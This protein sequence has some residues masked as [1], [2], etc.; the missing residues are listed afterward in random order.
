MTIEI[1]P[2]QSWV[3]YLACEEIQRQVW[4]AHDNRDIVP[5]SLLVTAAK[6][7]GVLLCAFHG[8]E[9][10]GFVFGFLGM[11]P[12][13]SQW[14]FKHCSHML[15]VLQ[16]YR[17]QRVGINLKLRQRQVLLAQ[18]LDLATWTYDPLQAVNARLN[19]SRL[20]AIARR[21]VRDAY[22]E[23]S[24]E[25]N[26]GVA[27]DRFEAEWWVSSARVETRLAPDFSSIVTLSQ[28]PAIYDI[29]FDW[30]NLPHVTAEQG[31]ATESIWLEI[32]ANFNL[33]RAQDLG[34]ACAWRARTRATLEKAFANGYIAVDFMNWRD[35][36]GQDRAAYLL[37]KS[38]PPV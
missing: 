13:V 27:S 30:H 38:D 26:A 31:L 4:R 28:A 12:G 2:A 32:P 37:Q 9:I 8:E 25:L 3:D 15:A 17:A 22:G 18:G 33:L 35:D 7:G 21:Y 10:V 14:H 24:D 6:N 1:R 20:G 29:E 34:L 11:E 36:L 5:A 19:L 16:A 23:M